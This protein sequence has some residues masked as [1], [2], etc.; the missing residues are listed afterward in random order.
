MPVVKF[1]LPS[2]MRGGSKPNPDKVKSNLFGAVK[3]DN[4]NE[5]EEEI[6]YDRDMIDNIQGEEMPP[7]WDTTDDEEEEQEGGRNAPPPQRLGRLRQQR[8]REQLEALNEELEDLDDELQGS[9]HYAEMYANPELFIHENSSL[10]PTQEELR[11][12]TEAEYFQELHSHHT[13]RV[14][15]IPNEITEINN[16]MQELETELYALQDAEEQEG[17]GKRKLNADDGGLMSMSSNWEEN[18]NRNIGSF[19][20]PQDRVN[21]NRTNTRNIF[22]EVTEISALEERITAGQEKRRELNKMIQEIEEEDD[23]KSLVI[24]R[25]DYR[26]AVRQVESINTE[27]RNIRNQIQRINEREQGGQGKKFDKFKS[28]FKK[29]KTKSEA[30]ELTDF[31]NVVHNTEGL[32]SGRNAQS[33]ETEK[34][35]MSML[36]R[37]KDNVLEAKEKKYKELEDRLYF[38]AQ[39]RNRNIW[40][41]DTIRARA[42]KYKRYLNTNR[43]NENRLL[44]T[45]YDRSLVYKL[46]RE[47]DKI[48]EDVENQRRDVKR[49]MREIEASKPRD[50]IYRIGGQGLIEDMK[51]CCGFRSQRRVVP[52]LN[53][54]VSATTPVSNRR[55]IY[56]VRRGRVRTIP[57]DTSEQ[58][59]EGVTRDYEAENSLDRN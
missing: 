59:R 38:L 26:R 39:R 3:V 37:Q 8:L 36:P 48:V 17:G 51:R 16:Q 35:I 21:A 46:E 13:E 34:L 58:R 31:A 20:S 50:E 19:L 32:F 44:W 1:Y 9:T 33:L 29:K 53:T 41:D 40:L 25:E 7:E 43:I 42:S 45:H 23:G 2:Q 57:T 47:Y 54:R 30:D 49:T 24:N 52:I 55:N 15:D 28:L 6:E 56:V 22:D 5:E 11:G 4:T 18:L 27:I 12:L 14:R 10:S